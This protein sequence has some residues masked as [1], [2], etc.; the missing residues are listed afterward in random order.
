MSVSP[1]IFIPF[2]E[3]L[4]SERL[5]LKDYVWDTSQYGASHESLYGGKSMYAPGF[6]AL[7]NSHPAVS[8]VVKLTTFEPLL[9]RRFD[10]GAGAFTDYESSY[11]Y[12]VNQLGGRSRGEE[13]LIQY[14]ASWFSERRPFHGLP[15]KKDYDDADQVISPLVGLVSSTGTPFS[16]NFIQDMLGLV[17]SEFANNSRVLLVLQSVTS[18]EDLLHVHSS[19]GTANA[20]VGIPRSGDWLERHGHCFDHLYT[21]ESLIPQ[22]GRGAFARRKLS[23]DSVILSSPMLPI[24]DRRLMQSICQ[25]TRN[26][27][28]SLLTNYVFGHPDSSVTFLPSSLLLSVNHASDTAGPKAPNARIQLATW[29]KKGK[30]FTHLPLDDL[31]D[32]HSTTIVFDLVATRDVQA[33][34]EILISYGMKWEAAWSN[35][36]R[37][38]KTPCPSD[39]SPCFKSS[40]LVWNMNFDKFNRSYHSW[41]ADHFTICHIEEE[42][43]TEYIGEWVVEGSENFVGV[44]KPPGFVPS[45]DEGFNLMMAMSSDQYPC[46]IIDFD[47]AKQC[48]DV[49]F[50]SVEVR[51]A[52]DAKVLKRHRSISSDRV[53]FKNKPFM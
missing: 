2:E 36:V 43:V 50:Y 35:H 3:S 9:D 34:E 48:F 16:Q 52:T 19:N 37:T 14:G 28:R 53:M 31:E 23:K 27:S 40:K 29:N 25:G 24:F 22:A 26:T 38:W 32:L 39:Q 17:S 8:N 15:R 51:N 49:I 11:V 5:I 46:E 45:M 12:S 6:G 41:T 20:S 44:N 13:L 42:D 21:K 10:P 7:C 1:S 33:D 4:A 30:Y 47:E 18:A